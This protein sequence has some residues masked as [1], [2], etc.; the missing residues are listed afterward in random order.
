[1]SVTIACSHCEAD[2]RVVATHCESPNCDW[3]MKCFLA[4]RAKRATK[5]N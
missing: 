4:N 3:C 2:L 5:T 1:M